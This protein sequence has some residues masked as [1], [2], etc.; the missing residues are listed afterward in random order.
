MYMVCHAVDEIKVNA[1]FFGVGLDVFENIYPLV[2]VKRGGIGQDD[3]V[4]AVQAQQVVVLT[5]RL[6]GVELK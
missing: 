3:E 2:F 4:G 6:F 1:F 5:L